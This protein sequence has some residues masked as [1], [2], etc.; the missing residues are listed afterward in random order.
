[1]GSEK[2][3]TQQSSQTQYTPT[4]EEQA[5]Q[6]LQLEQMQQTMPGQ[7]QAQLSGLNLINQLLTG[8]EPLPGFFNQMSQGI[9]PDA[10]SKQATYMTGQAMPGLQSMGI[11]DS[12]EA[13]RSISQDIAN[14]LLFP[15]EQFNI[16]AKQ[17]LLNL[18]LSGQAQVQ[19]PVLAGQ[20]MLGSSL[21]GLRTMN[22]TGSMTQTSMNPFLKSFQTSLGS[23]LGSGSFGSSWAAATNPA[24]ACWVA[25]EIF[26]GW[27]EPKTV[28]ARYYILNLA[29]SWFRKFYIKYGERIAKFIHNKPILKLIL[30]PLFEYF[31]LKGKLVGVSNAY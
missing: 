11:L 3:Q 9:S 22:Q 23:S 5:M 20:Q 10:I 7:T 14:Q 17:N 6:K 26:G 15:A 31:A 24:G 28:M 25:S 13:M 12:G 19:Q 8:T 2:Q 1:M 18:A 4:P 30:R 29:P 16:G 27:F 21:A